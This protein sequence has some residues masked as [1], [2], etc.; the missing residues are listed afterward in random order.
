[1]SRSRPKDAWTRR[2]VMPS[3]GSRD[4]SDEK[5]SPIRVEAKEASDE[6]PPASSNLQR[7]ELFRTVEIDAGNST[8]VAFLGDG[9]RLLSGGSE[10][11]IR[12]WGAEDGEEVGKPIEARGY[13]WSL[14]AS[15]NGEWIARGGG[16]GAVTVWNA[17]SQ[18]KVNGFD[19]H[20]SGN[21][22]NGIDISPDGARIVTASRD[23][24]ACVWSR[25]TGE[26]LLG[27]LQH[28]GWVAAAKFSPDGSSIATATLS[29]ESVRIY[30]S[31]DGHCLVDFPI[32]VDS[33]FNGSV[34]WAGDSR[35]LFVLSC[36]GNIHA[37]DISTK[38]ILSRWPIHSSTAPNCIALASNDM[39]LAA[40]ANSSVSFWSITTHE[41]I[42]SVIKHTADI[43]S[44][45][46][47]ANYKL[48][49]GGGSKITVW[50]L[51][52][53][54]PSLRAYSDN[55]S[56]AHKLQ[57]ERVERVDLEKTIQFLRTQDKHSAQ[58][59]SN[60]EDTV[61]QLRNE[62]DDSKRVAQQM[63]IDMGETLRSL[64]G[65]LETNSIDVLGW[66]LRAHEQ[67]LECEELYDEGR[68]FDA[69]IAFLNMTSAPSKIMK[70]NKVVVDW[71]SKF[72][73]QCIMALE[74]IGD[75]ASITGSYDEILSA[76]STAL[77]LG[78]STSSD[79]LI[80][81]AKTM[82]RCSSVNQVLRAA[83][84]FKL[85]GFFVHRAICEAL[86]TSGRITEA[87]ACFQQLQNEI[88][89][90]GNPNIGDERTR[91]ESSFTLRLAE[92]L[93]T[94][95]DSAMNHG[96]HDDAIAHY[97]DALSLKPANL[98]DILVK[99]SRA[100]A[101]AGS[102][103]HALS[104]A[105]KAI[106][107][108][109]SFYMGYEAKHAALHGMK[110]YTE[111]FGAF[112]TMLS[113][114]ERSPDPRIR[115]LSLRYFDATLQIHKM[116]VETLQ[117]MP[118]VLID[119]T[120][121]R[122]Y[123]KSQQ[124]ATFEEQ[125]IFD[126]LR[127]SMTSRLD[128][129]R[130]RKEVESYYRYVTFSHTWEYGEPLFQKVEN[131]SIYELEPSTTNFKLQG[132]C[133]LTRSLGFQWVWSDTCCIDKKD[134][135][136][137]QESLVA[138][139][140]WYRGSSLT[141]V[142]L[143]GVRS[144]SQLSGDLRKSIWNTRGW[145]YQEYIAAEVIQF[146]TEDWKPYLG[147]DLFNH[148]ESPIIVS[149][150][151]QAGSVS[152]QDLVV[153]QPG[154]ERVREKLYLASTRK[155]TLVEDMAYSLLGIFN[156]AIPVIYGEGNRAL[157]R[158]LEHILTGSGDVTILA[159][160]GCS[161]SYHSC[162]PAHLSV[163]EQPILQHVPPLIETPKM[164]QMVKHLRRFLPDLSVAEMLY[165]RL[166]D[167]PTPSIAAS[168]LRLPGII[169]RTTEL[170]QTSGPDP[171][172]NLRVYHATTFMFGKLEMTTADDLTRTKELC[173][174]HPWIRPLFDQEFSDGVAAL[175]KTTQALRFVA[176]LR[177]PFGALLFAPLSHFEYR[178]V[179]A[180]CVVQV[181][182]RE[183]IPLSELVDNI[184]TIEVH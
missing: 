40:S 12:C 7:K 57:R 150:M 99:R 180:D 64:R 145:T 111:A 149:E 127:S 84:K 23:Q 55:I 146:Y 31:F 109:P 100:R 148:K 66:I 160:T 112:R 179:A 116:I 28:D 17:Q 94:M 126:E 80:K 137:L 170:V 19:A 42:G 120:T 141:V 101:M 131:I 151:Q 115:E 5:D 167:L 47:S 93:V 95:G 71:Q 182:F 162:L 6:S 44:M 128:S 60:L 73:D 82:F 43:V 102:L 9:T 89:L 48:A 34:A 87:I 173:V 15:Q 24:T 113:M 33:R 108:E 91:W 30:G 135:V 122:L 92:K 110:R 96:N 154:L 156:A 26:L 59:V 70:S 121:G 14:A 132:L 65:N 35:R 79:L 178:R 63:R 10:K 163:Y 166:H 13:V 142:Y 20:G 123:D 98:A 77:S 168:R 74:R 152:T 46:I 183:E 176:R 181:Q 41:Q 118:R 61:L 153:L 129:A 106:E 175:D 164:K 177:Q 50:D 119:A 72:K 86:E 171:N 97:S 133:K 69:A 158:F 76:Y 36:E 157:G 58:K 32:K 29:V 125:P 68:I 4:R 139:F 136:V 88:A 53:I 51:F 144:D 78:P 90:T 83:A 25:E 45:V 62:L 107:L 159:W 67:K 75:E 8:L 165:D 39:F 143:L 81:W 54:L 49:T 37:L 140:T 134:H 184:R 85:P 124:I 1:M 22:V 169:F 138:M 161:G 18:K 52:E 172:T 155:T 174:V 104:D 27:P 38:T 16:G 56:L 103:N 117:H 130:I 11:K 3:S 114:L 2:D 105:E 147:I 21:Q